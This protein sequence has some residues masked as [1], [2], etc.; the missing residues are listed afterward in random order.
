MNS[1][2]T[3]IP[4][5][6]NR[7]F[8]YWLQF[9]APLHK[10]TE[11]DMHVL[12]HLLMKRYELSKVITDDDV[13]DSYLFSKDV[14]SQVVEECRETP[15]NFAGTLSRLRKQNV[16]LPDNKLNKKFIPNLSKG[17]NKFDIMIIFDIKD[18]TL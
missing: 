3:K 16:I 5:T 1:S 15:I 11:K 4:C 17:S 8:K 18:D 12:S 14:R 7:F 6:L 2:V 13:I 10:L 9:T